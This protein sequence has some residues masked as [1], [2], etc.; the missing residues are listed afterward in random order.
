MRTGTSAV[1]AR[2]A[3]LTC[4]KWYPPADAVP[5]NYQGIAQQFHRG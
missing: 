1:G 4:Y 2:C 5:L 3:G